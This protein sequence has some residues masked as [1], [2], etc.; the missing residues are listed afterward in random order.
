MS[1]NNFNNNTNEYNDGY[2]DNQQVSQNEQQS[3]SDFEDISSS[4]VQ[5]QNPTEFHTDAQQTNGQYQ[6]QQYSTTAETQ[7]INF[8][9]DNNT[10]QPMNVVPNTDAGMP[11]KKS[12]KGRKVALIACAI[13]LTL[14]VGVG[15]G[16]LGSYL[17]NNG[18]GII[19]A[20]TSN[21]NES[22]SSKS[23]S[24]LKIVQA[25]DS[26][27]KPTTVQEVVEKTQNAV[28]EIT[29]ETT[30]YGSFYGQYVAQ[31]AGSGVII[32]SD[33]YI[34]TNNHVIDGASKIT[35]RLKDEKTYEAKLIGKDSTLDVALLKIEADNLTVATFGD[36]SKLAVGQTAIAIGN[37]LGKLGGTVTDGIISALDREIE[38]DGKT[39]TLL[40]TNAAINPGNS[41]GGLFDANGNLIGLVVAKSTSTSS[42]T[43]LEGLGFAIPINK[44]VDVLSDL[45]T[46][47]YVTGRPSLGVTIVDINDRE[48]QF[49]YRVN[50]LGAYISSLTSGG[51]AEKAGLKVG[52][53]IT[54]IDNKEVSSS[55]DI[56]TELSKHK[57]G[58]SIKVTVVRDEKTVT[59]NVTLGESTPDNDNSDESS[60]YNS[61][62]GSIFGGGDDIYDGIFGN[63]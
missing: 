44:I 43:S 17:A 63:N 15:G 34:I 1:E 52:D 20:N 2:N 26:E 55:S 7:P 37:P 9:P 5:P 60:T 59:V 58:D 12:K 41:G 8:V 14:C 54:K 32:S 33:G 21:S 61:D 50:Q 27:V 47:G 25:S 35:V 28:V 38:I 31:G 51:A 22:K 23:N 19:A 39:M 18:N 36:S 42:G 4:S 49:M 3:V 24:E 40:Q 48:K 57:A 45:K 6:P 13:A 29:T 56:K 62:R 16:F 10:V 46:N 11:P 30:Q 53:C